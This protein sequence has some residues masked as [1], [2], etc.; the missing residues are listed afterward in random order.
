[1]A[2]A[3][4]FRFK[5]AWLPVIVV[6]TFFVSDAVN[7]I[8][9][10]MNGTAPKFSVFIRLLFEVAAF[11]L[12]ALEL[13]P[14][15]ESAL[16]IFLWICG[17][18]FGMLGAIEFSFNYSNA[19][20]TSAFYSLNKYLFVYLEFVF[21]SLTT[22]Y[23]SSGAKRILFMAYDVIIYINAGCAILLGFV[24][25]IHLFESYP[26][27]E[28][29]GYKGFIPIANDASMFWLVSIFYS[30]CIFDAEKRKMPLIASIVAAML[31]GTKA[32]W[33]TVPLVGIYYV[34]KLSATK[35]KL[36]AIGIIMFAA[37]LI[38]YKLIAILELIGA[39]RGLNSILEPVLAILQGGDIMPSL[40]SGRFSAS[41]ASLSDHFYLN[42][43]HWDW[44]NYIFGGSYIG[45]E[46]D[47]YD[48]FATLGII[49]TILLIGGY[50]VI[51]S[52]I[53]KKYRYVFSFFLLLL[54]TLGGHVFQNAMNMTYLCLFV[55]KSESINIGRAC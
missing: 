15:K 54:A 13:R 11:V 1:M 41:G 9:W 40:S 42:L 4:C 20:T 29:F 33:L 45:T 24:A 34:W 50:A 6:A 21:L 46:M 32:L 44:I 10:Y 43:I 12:F 39:N 8:L 53:D 35:G 3:N 17:M 26:G 2:D 47:V 37:Y 49:G 51:L 52:K 38:Q 22:A 36:L 14:K 28:R 23:A 19:D 25:K 55:L 31:V 48:V 18:L 16:L 5:V 27:T 7:T 30:I